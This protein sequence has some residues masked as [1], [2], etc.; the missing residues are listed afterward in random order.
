MDDRWDR[1]KTDPEFW[2]WNVNGRP[3]TALFVVSKSGGMTKEIWKLHHEQI[4][5]KHLR[6]W[7]CVGS[8]RAAGVEDR[9]IKKQV[10][11]FKEH[12]NTKKQTK[13][14]LFNATSPIHEK[15][16]AVRSTYCIPTWRPHNGIVR[17]GLGPGPLAK[18]PPKK[19]L[20]ASFSPST[21]VV[22]DLRPASGG[23]CELDLGN[24]ESQIGGLK[25]G[26]NATHC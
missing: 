22:V 1:A 7:C 2:T 4:I 18:N 3:V 5:F 8:D 13:I 15:P 14:G 26:G 17:L 10:R 12:H 16:N 19:K 20:L 9:F 6:C 25:M 23:G 21:K 24:R 11:K